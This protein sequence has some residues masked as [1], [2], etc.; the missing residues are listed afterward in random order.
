LPASFVEGRNHRHG[1]NAGGMKEGLFEC[2]IGG[3]FSLSRIGLR[4]CLHDLREISMNVKRLVGLLVF[5]AVFSVFPAFSQIPPQVEFFSP[6]NTVKNVRQVAVRFSEAMVPLGSPKVEAEVFD[7]DCPEKGV[8]RWADERNWI[9]DFDRDL[10]AG[11]RCAFRVKAGLKTLAGREIGGQRLFAFSTG[12]PAIRQSFPYEG[13]QYIDDEQIFIL[14]L[15]AEAAE[16]SVLADAS[17]AVE[18]LIDRI[19]VRIISG[20]QRNEI[21][22]ARYPRGVP[23]G[24]PMLLLQARQRFPA[25]TRVSLVWGKGVRS[26]SG[27]P[28][29]DDQVLPFTTRA[30][31][32]VTFS[33]PREHPQAG[34]IPILPMSLAFSAPVARARALQAVLKG[35]AGASWKAEVGERDNK[36]EFLQRVSFRGPF[37]EKAGFTVEIPKDVTD[38]AGRRLINADKYPLKVRTEE[39][40]PL[41]KFPARFGII[42]AKG[43]PALPVTLRN[44]EASVDAKM[45]RAGN[46][47]SGVLQ[48][49]TFRITSTRI[50]GVIQ[51]LRRVNAAKRETS[52]F[53]PKPA[54]M[55][56]FTIPKPHGAKAFEVVG[57]PL[58]EPGFYVVEIA[59]EPLGA[60]L[61]GKNSVM[62][63]PTAALVTNL[64][65]HF[66]WGRDSSL[67]W[68][69]SLDQAKPVA[70]A[71]I[72]V[73]TCFGQVIWTGVSDANGLARIDKLPKMNETPQCGPVPYS[74]GL[75]VFAQQGGDMSFIHSSWDDG[76]EPWRFQ[77]PL[78]YS[79]SPVAA[80]TIFDR[81]LFRADETV[82]MKHLI[83]NQTM[84]GF[85]PTAAAER[86]ATAVIE[87]MGSNQQY[88][89]ALKWDRNGIAESTWD[90]PKDAKLGVY[91]VRLSRGKSN[92]YERP[93]Y[94]GEIRVEEF[95]VP[96]MKAS[97]QPP[98]EP[99]IAPARFPVDL[100]VRYLAGGG[101]AYQQVKLRSRVESKP[102]TSFDE[103]DGFVFANGEIKEGIQRNSSSD[104]YFY[105]P[106][107]FTSESDGATESAAPGAKS[108][109]ESIEVKLDKSGVARATISRLPPIKAPMEALTELEFSDPSGQIQTVS[110]RIPLWPANRLVG[111]KPDSWALSKDNLKFHVAVVDLNGKRTPGAPVKVDLLERRN[112]AHRKRLVGGLYAYEQV[113]EVKK[114]GE[115]CAGKSDARGL[116]ICEGKAPADGNLILQ[117]SATDEGG[118]ETVANADVWV[119]G[120]DQWWFAQGDH[121]RMDV[122]P[123]KKGYEPG[124]VARF[125][126]R[127][128][129]K[130]AT[131]LVTVEREGIID[132]FIKEVSGGEPVVEIP[133]R[134]NYAP[135]VFVSVLAVRGRVNEVQ[136][137]ALVDLGRPAYKLGIAEIN[138][139]WQAHELKVSVVPERSVYKVRE[140][141]RVK[142]VALRSD[143]SKP[144]PGSEAAIAAVDEGLLELMPNK[145]WDLLAA[146]MGR[147]SYSVTT[148]TA[149]MQVIGRRHFGLKAVAQGGGG[150][151]MITRELFD[152]LLYW[153]ARVP[154][155]ANGE[156]VV[157]IPLNDSLTAF[158]IAAV[159]SGDVGLFGSG[160]ASIRSSQDLMLFAGIAPVAREGDR[161]KSE[162]T[163]RNASDRPMQIHAMARIAG[164]D[165]TQRTAAVKL[166]AGEAKEVGWD[167]QVPISA[168][169]LVY[170]VEANESGGGADRLQVTQKISAAVP[171]RTHQATIR[172]VEK[173]LVLGIERPKEAL[174]GRGGINVS[175][176]PKLAES[177]AG[178]TEYMRW[179]PYTCMEQL[180]SRAVAL[181]DE[182]MWRANMDALPSYL[183]SAGL[184]KFF[185]DMLEGSETLT[186]Y[187]L[188]IAQ[189]AGWDIP[190]ATRARM[191]VAL[192][193]F[194]EGK[195]LRRSALPTA[196]LALR[197]MAAVDALARWGATDV[198]L[199]SSI[200]V[201]PN[202]WPTSGVIDWLNVLRSMPD[203]PNRE[204]KIKQ[205]EQILRARLNF[206]GTTMNFST[207]KTD[208][209]WWL[210][211]NG[212]V[213]AVRLILALLPSEPWKAD[214]PRLAQGALLRQ[215]K[216]AWSSTVAN[217]WGVLAFEKF[218][219]TFESVPVS[220][221]SVAKLSGRSQKVEWTEGAKSVPLSFAWPAQRDDVVLQHTGAGKPWVTVQSL[222]ALPLKQPLSSGYKITKQLAPVERKQAGKWS[223]GDIVRVT[224]E[225]EAQSDMTWVVV[226]DPIPAGATILGSGLGRDS[227]LAT[228]GE[229]QKG[230][231]WPAYQERTFEGYRVYYQYVPKGKWT[232][233]YTM[234]LNQ[235]GNFQLP[236]TRVEAMYASEMFGELPQT[237]F[238][239][240][241]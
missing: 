190:A 101:A 233:E 156:A 99:L 203:V 112:Y 188:A 110:R 55:S 160:T 28:T 109:I 214:M 34:C 142:I 75:F 177:L 119:A 90:I 106:G 6:Q 38:D 22:K 166:G 85:A 91:R 199:L 225:L 113:E 144:P 222:A 235:A 13:S 175:F 51:W 92:H 56:G 78:D 157:E 71:Q 122:L 164:L 152:T 134:G 126:V 176:R 201:D 64:S 69:T 60:A 194:I 210:M 183:D 103:F 189:E 184:V 192:R 35:P 148:S 94:T 149:Q 53:D 21:L 50:D 11:V 124:D 238:R 131:A 19:G 87:H 158:R 18:G 104:E 161:L 27:V 74:S 77:L 130:Q 147:R 29:E 216:G 213:N 228:E 137:T 218:S 10:S 127:M 15:D 23:P 30:A 33:C 135:N 141:A 181:R 136:P 42:E 79:P 76:I 128:P 31:F 16:D 202:L 61:I 204:Q 86:P 97:I 62:Y 169:Q 108:K 239:V 70:G 105:D 46:A 165:N 20:R 7:I 174:P 186:S 193:Q 32:S 215:R 3:W 73:A 182:K 9:Y 237:T 146:M 155:D 118:R 14:H 221:E 162:F 40:P 68:V 81:Q 66:K 84:Y 217:A 57:I 150:G 63:V 98:A 153:N 80:H 72:Q 236:T 212:D 231:V 170:E 240:D 187:L 1:F 67:V 65:V 36:E 83:R 180:T 120:K 241:P 234:R 173:N 102:A 195:L 230:W 219:G 211:V 17:F 224:L 59:S 151:K 4:G 89:L 145:S 8:A 5:L 232:V 125:Q 208:G 133:I 198:S 111:V 24:S 159:V 52:I 123:E 37:P 209:L 44:L 95:R 185:P 121:D 163:V 140:R 143:G 168:S 129:F 220:G 54:R 178:V 43:D 200:T 227:Q 39:Y 100:T 49:Q 48:G 223:K 41:A 154:L 114:L 206:Q 2:K 171:T 138:V 116:L 47:E 25:A 12:G 205:A 132:A 45:V 167:I 191:E 96:L 197:K 93:L 207:E 139:K 82:H 179:Y 58:K 117:A 226:D 26:K 107:E 115:V 229:K 196:D 88:E 172:Q